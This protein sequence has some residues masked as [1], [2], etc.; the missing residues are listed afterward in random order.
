MLVSVDMSPQ[1]HNSFVDWVLER[2]LENCVKNGL[3][4]C[5][6]EVVVYRK[7]VEL[8][9]AKMVDEDRWSRI[10]NINYGLRGSRSRGEAREQS[11]RHADLQACVVHVVSEQPLQTSGCLHNRQ[12]PYGTRRW[13]STAILRGGG[14]E[15]DERVEKN[16][17]NVMQVV[18]AYARHMCTRKA[19]S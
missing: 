6:A 12:A 19:V 4:R 7:R 18:R 14:K 9:Y 10:L 11:Q 16:T 13:I 17:V 2:E 5:N 3:G 15:D 1:A 8:K